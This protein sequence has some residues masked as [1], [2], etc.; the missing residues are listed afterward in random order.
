LLSAA[1][2]AARHDA[3]C[4]TPS[5]TIA[6]ALLTEISYVGLTGVANHHAA[7][8]TTLIFL[9]WRMSKQAPRSR[10]MSLWGQ[11]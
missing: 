10:G 4:H 6:L 11:Q 3:R 2:A 9:A 8:A 5:Q 1:G 7:L